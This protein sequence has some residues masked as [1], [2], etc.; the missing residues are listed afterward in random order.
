[1]NHVTFTIGQGL[2]ASNRPITDLSAKRQRA[3]TD[4]AET[5]GGYTAHD[6]MGGW[7]HDGALISEP[8]LSVDVMTNA[9]EVTIRAEASKLAGIFDQSAV[10]LTEDPA[11]V[12][13]VEQTPIHA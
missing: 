5:F 3:L 1:M 4:I 10:M 6:A 9:P 11:N 2:D 13:F 12:A 7:M 8:S